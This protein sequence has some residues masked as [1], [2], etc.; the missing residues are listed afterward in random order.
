MQGRYGAGVAVGALNFGLAPYGEYWF[1]PQIGVSASYALLGTL[2]TLEARAIYLF[3]RKPLKLGP[4]TLHPYAAAGYIAVKDEEFG[5]EY[6]GNGFELLGGLQQIGGFRGFENFALAW[7]IGY[8]TVTL[9][10]EVCSVNFCATAE[11]DYSNIATGARLTYFFGGPVR[12]GHRAAAEPK[13]ERQ[14]EEERQTRKRGH[15]KQAG[16]RR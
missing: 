14:P 6:T 5:V 16:T 9:E 12:G 8:S 10:A 3:D 11:G 4:L 1:H 2:D 15:D 13:R 7:E